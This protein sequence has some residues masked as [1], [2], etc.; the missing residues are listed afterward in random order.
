MKIPNN[1]VPM[2]YRDGEF[3]KK[4]LKSGHF[5][6][7]NDN[8][9]VMYLGIDKHNDYVFYKV[10]G[11]LFDNPKGFVYNE[12]ERYLSHHSIQVSSIVQMI[13]EIMNQPVDENSLVHYRNVPRIVSDFSYTNKEN[14]VEKWY[15]KTKKESAPDISFTNIKKTSEYVNA[16]DLM[17]G[18]LYYTG[19]LWRSLY[20]YLGRDSNNN[21]CWSFI[22][23][24]YCLKNKE[25]EHLVSGFEK[26]KTNKKVHP[27]EHAPNDP[28][29]YI[30]NEIKEFLDGSFCADV[31][32]I[33]LDRGRAIESFRPDNENHY[34]PDL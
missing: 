29:A 18:K 10:C 8:R 34:E 33:D 23:N 26:T 14:V 22:G 30:Y 28:H 32:K 4:D 21:F 11:Y 3:T 13:D 2:I 9:I 27:I 20:C 24:E 5:Y 15:T 16:K 6:A 1:C 7:T 25:T 19:Q 31:S 17:P 12:D